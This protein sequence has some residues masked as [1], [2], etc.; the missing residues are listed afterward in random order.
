MTDSYIRHGN[1]GSSFVGPAAVSVFRAIVLAN[2][3][4][5]YGRTGIKPNRMWSPS[6]MINAAEEITGKKFK[7]RDYEGAA[8]AVDEWIKQVRPTI[9][10]TTDATA[11]T[12]E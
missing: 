9:P 2:G 12:G 3:L 4:R 8:N 6:R 11:T 1:G 10:E 7:K 5:M